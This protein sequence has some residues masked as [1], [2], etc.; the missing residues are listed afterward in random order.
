[1]KKTT[2]TINTIRLF[3]LISILFILGLSTN[4]FAQNS[5]NFGKGVLLWGGFDILKQEVV[6]ELGKKAYLINL[7][8]TEN[9]YTLFCRDKNNGDL[10]KI[11]FKKLN[12]FNE[13]GKYVDNNGDVYYI[14][15]LLNTSVK[16]F[17]AVCSKPLP[18]LSPNIFMILR[19][20]IE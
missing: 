18:N 1:M 11:T 13:D 10:F 19:V 17:D 3:L 2:K 15:D 9:S 8:K 5:E 12:G 6:G 7:L 14:K 4:S 16:A 20:Y